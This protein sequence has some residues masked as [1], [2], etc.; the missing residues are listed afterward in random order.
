MLLLP[1]L[2]DN[3][4]YICE[5][6]MIFP[7]KLSHDRLRTAN[8]FLVPPN[9]EHVIIVM[10]DSIDHGD[11]LVS[12]S[13][14]C[15]SRG[16]ALSSSLVRFSNG[17]A[18]LAVLN[19]TNEPILLTKGTVVVSSVDTQPISVVA[20]DTSLVE[21]RSIPTDAPPTTALVNTISTDLTPPQADELLAL[22][23]KHKF[24]FD[25][26]STALS[27]T[28][29]V[30]HRIHTDGTSIVRR[31]PYRVSSSE[32]EIIDKHVADMLKQNI[33][34]P[35]SSPWSSPVVL[36]RKKRRFGAILR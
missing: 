19:I 25:V 32:R 29:A 33:I 20:S 21:S 1:S 34:R 30:A 13:A 14:R 12:P 4:S 16:I 26:H 15:L 2:V 6:R 31:R 8:D 3:D 23:S 27:Q 18:F 7:P 5:R 17:T 36:V 24:S 9:H 28:S 22:L 10:S 35:C 11:V